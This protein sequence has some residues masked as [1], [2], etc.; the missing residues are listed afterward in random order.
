MSWDVE[1]L[2]AGD[3]NVELY[4]TCKEKDLGSTIQLG[5]G[6]STVETKINKANDPPPR[7]MEND[8][9]PRMESYVKDFI[10]LTLGTISLQKGRGLLTVKAI[11]I[12]GGEAGEVRL[13]LFR[14]LTD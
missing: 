2:Q 11:D 1:V 13:L 5:L 9:Y 8:R 7:G 6:N 14:H 3:Y 12:P 10:P 4:Y